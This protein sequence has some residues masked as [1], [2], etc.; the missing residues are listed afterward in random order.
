VQIHTFT[1]NTPILPFPTNGVILWWVQLDDFSS[2]P[3]H[4]LLAPHERERATRFYFERDRNHYIIGRG[5]LRTLLGHYVNQPPATVPITYSQHHKPLLATNDFHFNI[6]HSNGIALMGFC[7]HAPIGVDV[8]YHRQDVEW[9]EIMP[10]VYTAAEQSWL[11]SHPDHKQFPLFY[12]L[13]TRKEAFLKARG[14]GLIGNPAAV[15]LL[16]DEQGIIAPLPPEPPM[17]WMVQDVAAP[18]NFSAAV[19]TTPAG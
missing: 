4:P 6:A 1:P 2:A 18:R 14:E 13:W 19:C 16:P 5:I 17:R 11:V 12:T 7:H 9:Q 3:F 15:T 8:E 10:L